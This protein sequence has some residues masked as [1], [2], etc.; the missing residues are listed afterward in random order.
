MSSSSQYSRYNSSIQK[1]KIQN[2][3]Q[4]FQRISL[5]Q[6]LHTCWIIKQDFS[7]SHVMIKMLWWNVAYNTDSENYILKDSD[8]EIL[9]FSKTKYFLLITNDATWK[10]WIYFLKKKSDF[11]DVLIFFFNY[12][13]NLDIQFSAVLKSD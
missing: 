2:D 9:F 4:E 5:L 12:L 7:H 6:N 3:N 11:F 13:K 10:Y 8:E 1:L